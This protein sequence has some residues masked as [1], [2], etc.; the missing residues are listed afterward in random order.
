LL[1]PLFDGVEAFAVL[2]QRVAALPSTRERGDA[3]EVFA[4]A[5]LATQRITE[6]AEVWPFEAIPLR[7][8]KSLGL[9]T[10]RDMGVDGVYR[11]TSGEHRAYQVKFR[12]GRPKLTW[13]ELSTFM[14]LSD[15]V[16]TRVLFTNCDLPPV[17][18]ATVKV[19]GSEHCPEPL[20]ATRIT[21]SC[22]NPSRPTAPTSARAPEAG[23]LSVTKAGE[24]ERRTPSNPLTPIKPAPRASA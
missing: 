14:G 9:D 11:T 13:E 21:P 10:G 16:G 18:R 1:S 17:C 3:F 24:P 23:C 6:T 20:T 22:T 12:A 4:E 8:R 15:R 2:E 5:Y 19:E 7:E